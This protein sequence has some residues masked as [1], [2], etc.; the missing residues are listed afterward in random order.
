MIQPDR[1]IGKNLNRF[2]DSHRTALT[3]EFIE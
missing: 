3:N 1:D 2:R